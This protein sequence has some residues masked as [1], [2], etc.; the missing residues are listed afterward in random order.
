[1]PLTHYKFPYFWLKSTKF[2]ASSLLFRLTFLL[3]RHR[4]LIYFHHQKQKVTV[5]LPFGVSNKAVRQ[6]LTLT[7]HARYEAYGLGLS[8]QSRSH[9]KK[10]NSGTSSFCIIF[11]FS[12][13]R[14][15]LVV[16]KA[17][18]FLSCVLIRGEKSYR[19]AAETSPSFFHS[20]R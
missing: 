5:S 18:L 16:P 10:V 4:G 13:C 12:Q 9:Q 20:A 19:F 2:G 3:P 15:W 6:P 7:T 14:T 8:R 17:C 11:P 1:M